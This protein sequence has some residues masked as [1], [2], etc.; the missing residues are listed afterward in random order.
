MF[1]APKTGAGS[2]PDRDCS[3]RETADNSENHRAVICP[4]QLPVGLWTLD[5]GLWTFK[6]MPA[7]KFRQ[8]LPVIPLRVSRRAAVRRQ[9]REEFLDPPVHRQRLAVEASVTR[10]RYNIPSQLAAKWRCVL[11]CA[12]RGLSP[13]RSGWTTRI[14]CE[15]GSFALRSRIS[16]TWERLC[17]VLEFTL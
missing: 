3:G 1:A 11:T 9:M 15:L 7:D 10:N 16:A 5:F 8:R 12:E 4:R 13:I 14:C 2:P 17:A 6:L